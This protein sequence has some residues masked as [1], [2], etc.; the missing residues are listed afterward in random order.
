[1][2]QIAKSPPQFNYTFYG[3]SIGMVAECGERQGVF[4]SEVTGQD[5]SV[6][7][8]EIWVRSAEVYTGKSLTGEP[9]GFELGLEDS[10]GTII[11]ID[12]K[13]VGGLPRPYE[14]PSVM[15]TMLKT[16]RFPLASLVESSPKFKAD[17]LRAL[18]IRCNR[19]DQRP[20]AFDVLQVVRRSE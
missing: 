18:L 1:M 7:G 19:A 15:K 14:R 5:T 9:S 13:R 10:N 6:E 11:W 17:S 12:S 3:N 16:L 4:R 20:L 8:T 2:S